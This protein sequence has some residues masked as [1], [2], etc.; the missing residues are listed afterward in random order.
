M[1]EV[2]CTPPR[3]TF[4]S[5]LAK[6]EAS[7]FFMPGRKP[8]RILIGTCRP[9]ACLP[10]LADQARPKPRDSPPRPGRGAI[11]RM[12]KCALFGQ[13][14]QFGRKCRTLAQTRQNRNN[15][16]GNIEVLAGLCKSAALLIQMAF[17]ENCDAPLP[18][19]PLIRIRPAGW[20][21]PGLAAAAGQLIRVANWRILRCR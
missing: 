10:G 2:D 15:P 17:L 7:P 3:R 21:W 6:M 12:P 18:S 19:G 13:K 20:A 14:R 5:E 8:G 1:L 11:R 4:S 16:I 9:P